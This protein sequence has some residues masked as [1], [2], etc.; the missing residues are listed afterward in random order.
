MLPSKVELDEIIFLDDKEIL[1]HTELDTGFP[2]KPGH[3]FLWEF[4]VYCTA[5]SKDNEVI[6]DIDASPQTMAKKIFR[7]LQF[8][9]VGGE[10]T[11]KNLGFCLHRLSFDVSKWKQINEKI[12]IR[13]LK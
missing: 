4:G 6:F 3:Y 9:P 12:D 1:P 11:I 5:Y 7:F 10:I 8:C 2:S 13:S